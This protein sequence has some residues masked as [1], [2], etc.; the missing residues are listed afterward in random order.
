[1][2]VSVRM[3]LFVGLSLAIASAPVMAYIDP[4]TGSALFY[5]VTGL[6]VSAYFAIRGL[7]YRV[8]EI[9][10]RAGRRGQKCEVA[11]HCEDPRYEITFLP[12]IRELVRRGVEVTIFT[13][14]E[15][16]SAFPSLPEGVAHV[17]IPSG[18][19]GYA[20][21]NNIEA[22][23]FV[24]TTPQLDVMTFRRSRR[25]RHYAM[26]QHALG[27]SRFVRPYAYDYFDSVLCCGPIVKSNIRRM[28]GIRGSAPKLLL[29]S[30]I[31]HYDELLASAH[32]AV[33]SAHE[34]TVLVAPSWG[35]LSMFSAY[36]VDFVRS[37]AERY[38]VIVR[39]HPQM[40][41]SQPELYSQILAIEGVEVDT[42]R[43]PSLAM[44]RADVLLSDISGIAHEF[45]FI[46]QRPVLVVDREICMAGLEGELLGGKSEL[47]AACADFIVPISSDD[48][49]VLVS[50]IDR[51]LK[52]HSSESL[53]AVRD[54]VVYNFGRA[55]EVV[56]EQL[57]GIYRAGQKLA[58]APGWS[59]RISQWARG[60]QHD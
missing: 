46:H 41:V 48:M 43:T 47:K 10:F 51:V 24:T 3:R 36:G 33:P 19:V 25:V 26:I 21:L 45:A 30:G 44:A 7:F 34:T 17:V 54:Q 55:S 23:L 32:D 9:A 29:E 18:M 35:P 56:A 60:G 57:E 58:P 5:V 6:I 14:Y 4:G 8:V 11:I 39:P 27:E 40:R 12:V 28:E 59:A 52:S 50:H 42:A 53:A 13:M 31:P 2:K 16:D 38:R 20:Y 37:I 1:M 22:G 49:D 15:R